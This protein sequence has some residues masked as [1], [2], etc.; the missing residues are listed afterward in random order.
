MAFQGYRVK[1]PALDPK[2]VINSVVLH[3]E[4][5]FTSYIL[6][7]YKELLIKTNDIDKQLSDP[8]KIT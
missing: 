1:S 2:V 7:K 5:T 8:I 4:T 6:V 3:L